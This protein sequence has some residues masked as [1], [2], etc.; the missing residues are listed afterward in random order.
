[1][2][3]DRNRHYPCIHRQPDF[4][5]RTKARQ[6]TAEPSPFIIEGDVF[7]QQNN[8]P[9]C[10]PFEISYHGEVM[11]VGIACAFPYNPAKDGKTVPAS[12]GT[13]VDYYGYDYYVMPIIGFL[14][15]TLDGEKIYWNFMNY[16]CAEVWY[17]SC[18]RANR[19]AKIAT[20]RVVD[21]V[22]QSC[23]AARPIPMMSHRL[24]CPYC[25]SHQIETYPIK[26][27]SHE[28]LS[29]LGNLKKPLEQAAKAALH[30]KKRFKFPPIFIAGS[31][32]ENDES[33]TIPRTIVDSVNQN[34]H[35]I[36]Y[37]N[38]VELDQ[39]NEV[40]DINFHILPG[41]RSGVLDDN[42][43]RDGYFT[44]KGAVEE[45]LRLWLPQ[46]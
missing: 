33:G 16:E 24:R 11:R 39:L 43:V 21:I 3:L 40:E 18:N 35:G 5:K 30:G 46:D 9:I 4:L 38:T 8:T 19:P 36:R 25:G 7:P 15:Y 23:A 13:E 14:A 10:F 41:I 29:M 6:S 17:H 32:I 28:F 2:R 20:S 27:M 1:M 44:Q 31:N 22:C 12:K 37:M 34:G 26:I 45:Y 42:I